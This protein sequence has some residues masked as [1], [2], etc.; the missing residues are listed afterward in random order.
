MS[1]SWRQIALFV[2][3]SRPLN[4]SA[5]ALLYAIGPAIADYLGRPIRPGILFAGLALVLFI[6]LMTHYVHA[7]SE[8]DREIDPSRRTPFTGP[9]GAVGPSRLPRIV[10]LSAAIL[11][12]GLGA[13]LATGLAIGR[14]LPIAAWLLLA[15]IFVG[16]FFY[17]A[18]PLR[19][20]GSGYGE[21]I[22]AVIAAGLVPTFGYVIQTGE[23]HRF[24]LMATFPLVMLTF[25]MFIAIELPEYA[26]STTVRGGNLLTRLGWSTAMRI[27]DS[28]ILLAILLFVLGIAAGLPRRLGTGMLIPLPLAVGQIWQMARI[29]N[30]LPPRWRLLILG[31]IGLVIL[32]TYLELVGFLLT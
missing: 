17:D 3:I 15:L 4:L 28:A 12:I 11:V 32:T 16:A 31:A 19:L 8:P 30:G 20:S 29:R 1:P 5:G 13:V 6:Q 27:H 23:V 21:I 7:Y 14:E 10:P 18:A 26:L 22:A 9:S 24:L 25:A 2:R